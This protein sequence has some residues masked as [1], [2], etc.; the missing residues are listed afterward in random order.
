MNQ[1]KIDSILRLV[2]LGVPKNEAMRILGAA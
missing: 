1:D 2:K